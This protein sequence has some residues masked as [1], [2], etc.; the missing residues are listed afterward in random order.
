MSRSIRKKTKS[1]KLIAFVPTREQSF[2]PDKVKGPH[3]VGDRKPHPVSAQVRALIEN[4]ITPELKA[5]C[6]VDAFYDA[7]NTAYDGEY[8]FLIQE[9]FDDV[10]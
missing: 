2:P 6:N 1:R 5:K 3:I 9:N 10:E 7:K 8:D 4:E